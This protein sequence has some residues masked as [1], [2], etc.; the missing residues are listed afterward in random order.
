MPRL[1]VITFDLDNTLWDVDHV[2]GN[3][4]RQMRAWLAERVPEYND[5]FGPDALMALRAQVM[6]ENPALA[7]DL[8]KLRKEL[9]FRA[10]RHCGYADNQARQHAAGAFAQFYEA[11]HQVEFF[12]GALEL[13]EALCSRYV[14]GALT[15]GNADF[16]KLRLARYFSFG[17]S[18]AT[19]GAAKPAPQMFQAALKHANANPEQSVHVGDHLVD[20]VQ[21]AAEVGMHTVWV[22]LKGTDDPGQGP[23]PSATVNNL[24]GV[25]DAIAEIERSDR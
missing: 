11:R 6:E 15:N 9:L 4:E 23:K 2:I 7:T 12:E 18:S 19:V 16:A 3:A 25:I 5:Q 20:D 1:K 8:S 21:G 13:L 22:N 10:I 17:Y 24:A 14:L